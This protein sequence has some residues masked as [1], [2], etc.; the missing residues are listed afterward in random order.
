MVQLRVLVG[1]LA[2]LVIDG[3]TCHRKVQAEEPVPPRSR[4]EG[5]VRSLRPGST[6][7]VEL[8]QHEGAHLEHGWR[9]RAGLD[10]D[11]GRARGERGPR[12]VLR[13]VGRHLRRAR[14]TTGVGPG[15]PT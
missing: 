14:R 9:V 3:V 4:I 5:T 15:S 10:G 7:T 13:P 8:I 12:P 2:V 6:A 1:L 11:R